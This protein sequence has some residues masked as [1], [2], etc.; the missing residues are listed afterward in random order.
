MKDVDLGNAMR[1]LPRATASPRFTSDVMRALRA[2]QR[3]RT[4]WRMVAATA[5]VLMLVAG[6]YATSVHRERQKINALRVE[7]R[8]LQSELRRV[9]AIADEVEPV[10]VLENGDMRV[11]VDLNEQPIYY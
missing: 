4:V 9:K 3:Q 6:G 10:V 8:Q 5:T 11:I 2:A 7:Q 1:R